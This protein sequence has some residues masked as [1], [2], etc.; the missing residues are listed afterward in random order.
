MQ[1]E[2]I[3]EEDD[4]TDD[5]DDLEDGDTANDDSD[6]DDTD[7]C[8]VPKKPHWNR[9]QSAEEFQRLEQLEFLKW[10]KKLNRLQSKQSN[11]PPFEKNI[12]FWRQ[13]WKM[14]EISDV[15]IQVV[16]S[17]D[18]LFYF[19]QDLAVYVK[20]V[21]GLKENVLLVN[22][23]DYLSQ[24]QRELWSKHFLDNNFKAIFFSALDEDADVASQ[25]EGR[26]LQF[27][28]AKVYSPI[29]VLQLLQKSFPRF[30]P[31]TVG[32]LGYPNVGKSSTI[33]RF[34]TNK[35]LQVSPF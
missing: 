28:S 12:E 14:I 29:E 34:L 17:R 11:V 4:E 19:S 1:D 21:S 27:N 31:L 15:V 26:D 6:D 23:A 3:I 2:L 33:N 9:M 24:R 18:P 22:K 7:F 35:R 5:S 20:E 13:F 25:D 10:K 8:S 32:F 30:T 16:D